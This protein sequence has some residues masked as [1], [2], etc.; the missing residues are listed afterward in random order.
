MKF[1]KAVATVLEELSRAEKNF[2]PMRS[3]HEGL[4]I[5]EEE[6]LEFRNEV[7]WGDTDDISNMIVEV[8]Q[9]AAMCHRFLIDCC[10]DDD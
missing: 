7:Y 9:L 1:D 5:I 3:P 6:F 10:P 8:T 2:P 4:A